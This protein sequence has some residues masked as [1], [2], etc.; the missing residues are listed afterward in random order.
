MMMIIMYSS[1]LVVATEL[2]LGTS[3]LRCSRRDQIEA[4]NIG[5]HVVR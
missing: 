2:S 1:V 5:A 3:K 4:L